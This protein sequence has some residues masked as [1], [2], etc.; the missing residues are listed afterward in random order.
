[1]L[2]SLVIANFITV[3]TE[4]ETSIHTGKGHH[5]LFVKLSQE[6]HN[7]MSMLSSEE[8]MLTTARILE[9]S[10]TAT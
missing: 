10:V 8:A 5:M 4:S 7:K 3:T 2:G 6:D 1:M 9:G